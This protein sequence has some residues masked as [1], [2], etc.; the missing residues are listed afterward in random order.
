[1]GFRIETFDEKIVTEVMFR[2]TR[3]PA[4]PLKEAV[5]VPPELGTETATEEPP[6]T[7]V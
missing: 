6:A 5:E 2:L 4:V 1:L 3:W 7:I